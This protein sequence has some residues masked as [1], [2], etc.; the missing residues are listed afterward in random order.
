LIICTVPITH[1]MQDS[2]FPVPHSLTSF[3][4]WLLA[5]FLATGG[6]AAW[7]AA[8]RNRKKPEAEVVE[9]QARSAF[10]FAKARS[11][12]LQTD[13]S[14]GDALVRMINQVAL[15]HLA[16]EQAEAEVERLRNENEVYEKQIRWAKATFKV[17]G[18]PW[19]DD[20]S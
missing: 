6:G 13:I 12:D 8:W 20:P 5:G 11:I 2:P 1:E 18:I 4:W 14:H 15:T 16:K 7:Y 9:I 17:K 10:T 19:N 3:L